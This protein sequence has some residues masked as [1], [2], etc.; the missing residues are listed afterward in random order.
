MLPWATDGPGDEDNFGDDVKEVKRRRGVYHSESQPLLA[1][2]QG[3]VRKQ[4]GQ[5]SNNEST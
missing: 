2:S 5:T 4:R 1:G 3:K